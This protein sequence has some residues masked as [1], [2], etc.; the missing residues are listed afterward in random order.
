MKKKALLSMQMMTLFAWTSRFW[1]HTQGIENAHL[2]PKRGLPLTDEENETL[3]QLS[4]KEKKSFVKH[5]KRKY[6]KG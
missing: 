5:L 4:S 2:P 3:R 6:L 1:D